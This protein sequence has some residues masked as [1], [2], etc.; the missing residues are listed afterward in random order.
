MPSGPSTRRPGIQ[1][2]GLS[3]MREFFFA[4]GVSFHVTW[5]YLVYV[6]PC[7]GTLGEEMAFLIENLGRSKVD[8]FGSA[9]PLLPFGTKLLAGIRGS[10][11]L[12][13]TKVLMGLSP[14]HSH[15]DKPALVQP[16]HTSGEVSQPH[17]YYL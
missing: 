4:L 9:L 13:N 14:S 1:V 5:A 17:S 15:V 8:L 11:L 2:S 16:Y 6:P 3:F 7:S 10:L 12:L